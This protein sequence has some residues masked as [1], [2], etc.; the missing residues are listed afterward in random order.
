MDK[1]KE[2]TAP[3][4]TPEELAAYLAANKQPEEI[5]LEVRYGKGDAARVVEFHARRS[6]AAFSRFARGAFGE[7]ADVLAASMRFLV[8]SVV[9]A[10]Q[11]VMALL[12][13][14]YPIEA[15]ALA[16]KL[17]GIYEG[18]GVEADVKNGFRP[19]GQ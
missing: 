2:E 15:V 13:D 3:K 19:A 11:P 12:V 10:E 9:E 5:T 16:Q 18:A 17:A 8:D 1:I 7:G 6:M 4:A 14:Q